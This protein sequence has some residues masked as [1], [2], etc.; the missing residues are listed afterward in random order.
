M[1]EEFQRLRRMTPDERLA[2]LNSSDFHYRFQPNERDILWR[3][4]ELL[5]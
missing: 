5:P 2:R 3:M 1:R 4:V